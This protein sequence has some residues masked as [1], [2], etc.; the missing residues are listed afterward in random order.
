MSA[1]PRAPGRLNVLVMSAAALAAGLAWHVC[2]QELMPVSRGGPGSFAVFVIAAAIGELLPFPKPRGRGV[3]MS[4]A[5]LATYALLGNPPWAV[6]AAAAVSWGLAALV[7]FV[8]GRPIRWLDVV[9]TTTGAWATAGMAAL[10]CYLG[11]ELTRVGV[12]P[13][14]VDAAT[15]GAMVA[16]W[17]AVVLG[18]PLWEAVE[19]TA[20]SGVPV[21]PVY[22]GLLRSGWRGGVALAASAS[23][24]ALVYDVLGS[25]TLPLIILPLLAARGGLRRYAQVRLTYDQ[26]VRAMSRLPEELGAIPRGHGIRVGEL[27]VDVA[28]ELGLPDAEVSEIQQAAHLHELG[29]IRSEPDEDVPEPLVAMAGASILEEAGSLDNVATLIRRHRDPHRA[30]GSITDSRVP[31][32]SRILRTVCDFDRGLA[33]RF[34]VPSTWAALERLHLGTAYDHDPHVVQ[35]LTRVLD[36]RSSL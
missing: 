36:R 6:A 18:Y 28:R 27:A 20:E 17:S 23:L 11:G 3:P 22:H 5:V 10:G 25:W 31:L 13:S 30:P 19:D 32:G 34:D 1:A 24:G 7:R 14:S 29:R 33:G 8:A 2:P 35:A 4:V 21:S 12:V 16:V 15:M 26:T 9:A